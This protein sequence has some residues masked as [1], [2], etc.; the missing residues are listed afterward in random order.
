M[1]VLSLC[2]FGH[3]LQQRGLYLKRAVRT[4]QA[5]WPLFD[6]ALTRAFLDPTLPE[7]ERYVALF[8]YLVAGLHY[9]ADREYAYAYYPGALSNQTA[10]LN[11]LEGVC[12]ILPMIGAWI[13][14]GWPAFI[15]GCDGQPIDLL[16][17]VKSA[18]LAGT[19]PRSK[20]FWGHI[21]NRDQRIV[22]AADVALTVWLLRHHLW[23]HLNSG[24]KE[25]I[26]CWLAET[27][28]KAVHDN[29]WH[30]F[31]VLCDCVLAALG[32][33]AVSASAARHYARFKSFYV[34]NGWFSDGPGGR[35]D[36]YNAWGMHYPLYWISQIAPEFD[37]DFI[38]QSLSD[39]VA[40]YKYFFSTNGI[41][42]FGRSICYRMAAPAPLVAAAARGLAGITPGLAR[43]AL[44][45]VWAYFV[46]HGALRHGR[47][48]QGY[49]HDD[50]RLLDNYSGPGSSLWSTRSL[51]VAF[52]LPPDADFWTVPPQPLP[53]EEDNYVVPIPALGWEVRGFRASG[54]VSIIMNDKR[55]EKLG[56]SYSCSR[57]RRCLTD[58]V[59]LPIRKPSRL[60]PYGRAAYSSLHPFW[61]G[62]APA[63]EGR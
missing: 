23:P 2:R 17:L 25:R 35:F 47:I 53:I 36:Y 44:N 29:N 62:S 18:L 12:R 45:C 7:Q 4:R 9:H 56:I 14:A 15:Q 8:R 55:E 41:P 6:A 19:D 1:T 5:S 30:L 57:A 34:G 51:T 63:Q 43:R 38:A 24:E 26:C 37:A 46:A 39:F 60:R 58:R 52:H 3:H 22:E 33:D 61:L 49:W 32:H 48:T 13:S 59:G 21:G 42:I 40:C 28:G 31:P 20:R 16:A 27:K 54:E 11:A 50:L 10:Q